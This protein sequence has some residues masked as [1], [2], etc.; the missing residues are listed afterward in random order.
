MS[1]QAATDF[2]PVHPR[3]LAGGAESLRLA[4]RGAAL[5]AVAAGAC[6]GTARLVGWWLAGA[7]R[8]PPAH[9]LLETALAV[10]AALALAALGARWLGGRAGS[11]AGLVLAGFLY[12]I[13][14]QPAVGD[15]LAQLTVLAAMGTFALANVPGRSPPADGRPWRL[16]FFACAGCG[17]WLVG[18]AAPL[19]VGAACVLYLVVS[20][21]GKGGRFLVDPLG[22]LVLGCCAG[23][24]AAGRAGWWDPVVPADTLAPLIGPRGHSTLWTRLA[25]AGLW[26][27]WATLPFSPLI[28][29][30]VLGSVRDGH[31]ASL[32]WRLVACWIAVPLVLAVVLPSEANHL[33]SWA[34]PPLAIVGGAGLQGCVVRLRRRGFGSAGLQ[35]K[36]QG[37]PV[38]DRVFPGGSLGTK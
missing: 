28:V 31:H 6:A 17:L 35:A 12:G 10:A 19:A 37:I 33:L 14:P 1:R 5:V 29:A 38:K 2:C 26:L 20:G 15:R 32:F 21:D 4:P 34:L 27:G 8:G 13:W 11:L 22:L 25:Q 18:P 7:E 30:A 16:A 9:L 24:W 36:A 3:L 23:G